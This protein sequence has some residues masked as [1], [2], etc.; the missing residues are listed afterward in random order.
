[1]PTFTK[2]P[3]HGFRMNATICWEKKKQLLITD[4]KRN[5]IRLK[6]AIRAYC[7]MA[8]SDASWQYHKNKLLPH[9]NLCCARPRGRIWCFVIHYRQA[10][11]ERPYSEEGI[12]TRFTFLRVAVL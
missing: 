4:I 8:A 6:T 10:D 3:R 2:M 12:T 1:M 11:G 5:T 9:S 7:L